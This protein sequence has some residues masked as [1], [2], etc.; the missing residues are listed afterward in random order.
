[1]LAQMGQED[2]AL[3]A[4]EKVSRRAPG[5]LDMRAAMAA[6]HWKNGDEAKAE[7]EWGFACEFINGT[8]IRHIPIPTN[9]HLLQ[10]SKEV[11]RG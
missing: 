3:Q 7:E 4:M 8:S 2:R 5:S 1:M 10:A 6:L 11:V 9:S